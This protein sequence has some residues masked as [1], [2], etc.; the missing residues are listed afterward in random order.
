MEKMV[1]F[2]SFMRLLLLSSLMCIFFCN[3][4]HRSVRSLELVVWMFCKKIDFNRSWYI[5]RL[6][7]HMWMHVAPLCAPRRNFAIFRHDSQCLS[8]LC[9]LYCRRMEAYRSSMLQNKAAF[10]GK[11][12]SELCRGGHFGA[13]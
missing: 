4:V 2:G 9:I 5:W 11:T 8:S 7:E 6:R 10:E 12:V 3:V 13:D 1:A